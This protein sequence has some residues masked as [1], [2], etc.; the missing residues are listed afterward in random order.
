[1][2]NASDSPE[3]PRHEDPAAPASPPEHPD[4]E[5]QALLGFKPVHRHTRRRDGWPPERQR[6]F[7]AALAQTGHPGRAADRIGRTAS[8]AWTVRD[9]GGSDEF[10]EAWE[11]AV[12]LYHRRNPKPV[13]TGRPSRGEQRHWEQQEEPEEDAEAQEQLKAEVFDR[14]LLRYQKKLF[15]EREARLEGRIAEAD[16][17]VRQLSYIEVTLDLGS[18]GMR[19][20]DVLEI[21]RELAPEDMLSINVAATPLSLYLDRLRRAVWAE[22]DEPERPPPG[23]LGEHQAGIATGP[24]N[25]YLPAR[26]G[27][28]KTWEATRTRDQAIAAEAQRLWEEKARAEAEEWSQRV[29]GET[30]AG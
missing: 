1:M 21:F 23:P 16:F 2:E 4:P 10:I 12:A 20:A 29:G 6:E 30:G 15:Q 18:Q 19:A 22:K 24:T 26:D 3:P 25:A 9:S 8:G 7:I 27:H 17:M 5:I 14:I 11:N 13:R 28:K